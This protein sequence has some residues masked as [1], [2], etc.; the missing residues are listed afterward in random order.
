MKKILFVVLISL[1]YGIYG[2]CFDLY[3][4]TPNNSNVKACF[5]L[6]YTPNDIF[7]YDDYTRE[8]A[9]SPSHV[10]E[11]ATIDYNCHGYAWH[12]KEG[13]SKVWIENTDTNGTGNV[14][15]YWTDGS[16]EIYDYSNLP[17]IDNLKVYYGISGDSDHTAI[18][19]SDPDIFISK[20]GYG[21]RVAHYSNHSPYDDSNLTYYRKAPITGGSNVVCYDGTQFRLTNPSSS[22]IYWT[23]SD[24]SLFTVTSPG[25]PTTVSRIGSGTGSAT[26]TAY[27]GSTNGPIEAQK[28]ITACKPTINGNDPICYN[29][30]EFT[31]NDPPSG[32]IYWTVTSP[33]V[34]ANNQSS[35][36]DN[37]VT[38][39]RTGTS[40]ASG[41]LK[42]HS[43]N[44]SGVLLDTKTITPST[45]AA[46]SGPSLVSCT[47]NAIYTLSLPCS[48][49]SITWNAGS[50][51]INSGQGSSSINVKKDTNNTLQST[52]ISAS[53]VFSGGNSVVI[54]KT[55]EIGVPR[56]TSLSPSGTTNT[57]MGSSV[58]FIAYP[59][60]S[61][62]EGGYEWLVPSGVGIYQSK[63]NNSNYIT[64][65][66]EGYFPVMVRTYMSTAEGHAC[67]ISPGTYTTSYV[68]VSYYSPS[69]SYPNPVSDVLTVETG[70]TV[71]AK[72]QG[73]NLTYDVRLYDAQGNLLRQASNKGGAVQFN[74]SAL[75]DGIYYLHIYDG[76]NSTPEMQQIIVE[77]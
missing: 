4:Q 75:P 1:Q 69:P 62:S 3:V 22:T 77:H 20:M 67:T 46:I 51:S 8:Y 32:T 59:S 44:A 21:C 23:V 58:N 30:S 35:T 33:F 54:S 66:Q 5:G 48:T 76:V 13:G 60:L 61:W 45:P 38:I 68:N 41:T 26:L 34:F 37:P 7:G 74:V 6:G 47:G 52:S 56:I 55:V 53:C 49:Q 25:N 17:H 29:G 64:F 24:P 57:T 36:T 28:I 10:Y 15:K 42:A 27:S 2:Q 65:T 73:A 19:T 14:S 71:S 12:M 39:Y 72:A 63:Y 11:G 40:T 43:V 50:L 18:T 70:T 9:I 31:L 16:Y